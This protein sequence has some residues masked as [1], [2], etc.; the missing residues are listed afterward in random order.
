MARPVGSRFDPI[1]AFMKEQKVAGY[2]W[3]FVAGKTQTQYPW[4]S[5]QKQYMAEPSLWFHEIFRPNGD[6]YDPKEVAYIRSVTGRG[7][8]FGEPPR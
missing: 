8:K 2:N 7:P 4:D 1:L 6:P 3:G 5:W